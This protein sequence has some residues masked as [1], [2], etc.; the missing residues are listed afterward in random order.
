MSKIVPKSTQSPGSQN[1]KANQ[2]SNENTDSDVMFAA[3]FGGANAGSP[4]EKSTADNSLMATT[5]SATPYDWDTTGEELNNDVMAL[6]ASVQAGRGFGQKIAGSNKPT[7][8]R[9]S[10]IEFAHIVVECFYC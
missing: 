4:V 8:T 5:V 2:T 10:Q 3:L 1:I 7:F 6:M 9:N